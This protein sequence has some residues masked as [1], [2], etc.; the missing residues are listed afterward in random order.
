[1]IFFSLTVPKQ[2]LPGW[3]CSPFASKRGAE[4]PP[5]TKTDLLS[6][7]TTKEISLP[8]SKGKGSLLAPHYSAGKYSNFKNYV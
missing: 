1:M 6:H 2:D 5:V 3:S 8:M 4:V 7:S